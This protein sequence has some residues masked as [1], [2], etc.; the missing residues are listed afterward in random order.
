M[1][2]GA[3]LERCSFWVYYNDWRPHEFLCSATLATVF[4]DNAVPFVLKNAT[5]VP[6]PFKFDFESPK[7]F[8]NRLVLRDFQLL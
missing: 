6:F 1:L 7:W 3:F 2:S 4:R 8:F 5:G